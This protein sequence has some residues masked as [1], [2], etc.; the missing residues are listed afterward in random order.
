MDA[1]RD[2]LTVEVRRSD[3]LS[4]WSGIRPLAA[5]PSA[6]ASSTEAIVRDHVVA[7]EANGMVTVAGGKWTTYRLMAEDAVDLICRT[8]RVPAERCGACRTKGLKLLGAS[9][10]SPSLFTEVAQ[11][12]TVPHRPGAIDTRVAKNLA[13][14]Y[15]D[16]A[17]HITRLA[18]ELGLGKRLVRG[19]PQIEAEVVY[20]CRHEYCEAPE[21]FIAR[22]SRLAFLDTRAAA[23]ALPRVVELMAREKGWSTARQK[24]ELARSLAW[25]KGFDGPNWEEEHR[26]FKQKQPAM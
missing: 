4:A 18:E 9:G 23:E 24:A 10:Y 7:V 11:H 21:D 17:F 5:N 6:S 19:H 13:D 26:R 25:L 8:G 12:Y 14:S 16:R 3:V 15:G 22:R 20:C 2:Y 1:I